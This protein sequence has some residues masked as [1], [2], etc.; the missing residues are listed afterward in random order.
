MPPLTPTQILSPSCIIL[1]RSSARL[2]QPRT[3]FICI[4]LSVFLFESLLP[5]AKANQ[6]SSSQP[7]VCTRSFYSP[8]NYT[9]SGSFCI[10][11]F[12]ER[13]IACPNAHIINGIS[14]KIC[15]VNPC[16][17][18]LRSTIINRKRGK[19]AWSDSISHYNRLSV[20]L[21]FACLCPGSEPLFF[22]YTAYVV[23]RNST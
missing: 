4:F 20:F 17:H 12:V 2:M 9:V 5:R 16:G 15:P 11:F 7:S 1:Y 10:A 21:L 13:P 8:L 19:T 14:G 23:L 22:R 6:F 18:V 3:C